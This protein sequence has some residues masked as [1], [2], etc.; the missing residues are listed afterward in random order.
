MNNIHPHEN[1]RASR[2]TREQAANL[3]YRYPHVSEAE[4]NAILTF[5]R[6]GRHL[7]VGILTADEQLKPQ[8][9]SFMRDHAKYFRV[10]I[11]EGS[12]LVAAIGG[13][14]AI[15]WL[16]WKAVEPAALDV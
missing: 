7:D 2:L 5:L 13:L 11:V 1:G 8:L 9:D 10:G 4:E 6:K 3:L 14:L 15:C 12:A 16:I